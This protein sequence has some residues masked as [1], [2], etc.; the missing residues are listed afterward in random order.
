[1]LHAKKL[2]PQKGPKVEN[3]AEKIGKILDGENL[4][5]DKQCYKSGVRIPAPPPPPQ[6]TIMDINIIRKEK[7]SL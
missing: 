1:M 3:F 4:K 2:R 5:I 7:K 6:P